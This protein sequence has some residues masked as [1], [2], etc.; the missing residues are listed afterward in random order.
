MYISLIAVAVLAGGAAAVKRRN[1]FNARKTVWR[2]GVSEN[3]PYILVRPDGSVGGLAAEAME[4]A[5][6]RLGLRFQWVETSAAPDRALR[7]NQIDM[8]PTLVDLPNRR[9]PGIHFTDPWVKH[10]Y[11]LLSLESSPILN[12]QAA[13]GQ[14]VALPN[15]SIYKDI[16]RLLPG[17]RPVVKPDRSR[18]VQAVCAGEAQAAM[19]EY[20]IALTLL[21]E[22]PPGC[23]GAVSHMARIRNGVVYAAIGS[24]PRAAFAA[25]QLREELGAMARED[26][27]ADILSKWSLATNDATAT[28]LEV[29]DAKKRNW[30]LVYTVIALL[31]A[32]ALALSQTVQSR[33]A[34]TVAE[35]AGAAKSE[36]V[37][38]MS[39][40]IRTPMNGIIGMT[41]LVLAT[42]L[43]AEQRDYLEI[44]AGSAESLHSLL[45]DIL[46]FSKIE[47]GRLELYPAPFS[48]REC[49]QSAM[50]TFRG[51][52]LQKGLALSYELGAD[53]PD[54]LVGDAGRL[55]QVLLNLLSNAIKFTAA[56][57][58]RVEVG[59]ESGDG[60]GVLFRFAVIDTGLGVPADKQA[61]IFEA[62]RQADGSHTRKY[63]GTGLGL[64]ICSRLVELMGGRIWVES[65]PGV[66]SAFH[67]TARFGLATGDRAEVM[68]ADLRRLGASISGHDP[69]CRPLRIL[70]AEDN[71]VNQ[72]LAR[73]LLEKQGHTVAVAGNGREAVGLLERESF[74][75]AL[76]DI[77]MPELDGSEVARTVRAREKNTGA[78]LPIIALTA[79]AMLGD[80]ERCLEAGMDGYVSKPIKVS[81]L[82]TAIS[83]VIATAPGEIRPTPKGSG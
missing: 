19:I 46:D 24:T 31:G 15:R 62:F 60:P 73:R 25:D 27:L 68:P 59:V 23:E 57:S 22:R 4:V 65:R 34:R 55:R 10:E 53:A 64:T 79:H 47:A 66:G 70:L 80:R 8:W 76:L 81:E 43:S 42:E 45:N 18:T 61:F 58:V 44:V 39:H 2:L 72:K 17:I 7:E 14:L 54:R 20:H 30:G 51:P 26:K 56:G 69:Q 41:N 9:V 52:A 13:K 78:R 12:A 40:E 5:A 11:C 77:Q 49:M 48:L 83:Q 82:F 33:N 35:K 1:V 37:A 36:F 16:A 28:I 3:P 50:K 21:L 63:G 32:L 6:N 74:D 38:N 75:L 67:F 71:L 29:L